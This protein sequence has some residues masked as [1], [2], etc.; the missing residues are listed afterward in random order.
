MVPVK[1][2]LKTSGTT[3]D[4]GVELGPIR[5]IDTVDEQFRIEVRSLAERR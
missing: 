5:R 1:C 4:R 3:A 2:W